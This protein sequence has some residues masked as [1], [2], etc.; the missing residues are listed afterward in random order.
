MEQGRYW[1]ALF[2]R[3]GESAG[4]EREVARE[5]RLEVARSRYIESVAKYPSRLVMLCESRHGLGSERSEPGH[6]AGWVS[7]KASW[8][9]LLSQFVYIRMG[10]FP[11]FGMIE[12]DCR[13]YQLLQGIR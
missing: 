10:K 6:A 5:P 8:I 3:G 9:M 12:I 4:V 7:A 2:N 1:V 13:G 11:K